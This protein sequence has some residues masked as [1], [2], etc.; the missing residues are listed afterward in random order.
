MTWRAEVRDLKMLAEGER[1]VW[2]P[3]PG[4]P[5]CPAGGRYSLRGRYRSRPFAKQSATAATFL[6]TVRR[7]CV[8]R[9]IIEAGS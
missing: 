4:A 8:P 5:V 7:N 9:Q 1:R 2:P 6:Q 3:G